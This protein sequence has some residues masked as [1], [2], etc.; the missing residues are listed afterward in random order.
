MKHPF[1]FGKDTLTV[2][3]ALALAKGSLQGI[4]ADETLLRIKKSHADVA[5][6][7]NGDRV[8]YGVNTGFGPLCTT[9]ISR[10]QTRKL[11]ENILRSHSVGVGEHVPLEVVKLMLVTKLQALSYGYSGIAPE[12]LDRILWFLDSNITPVVP[13]Q[14]SV[15]ASG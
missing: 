1:Q 5:D 8:V 15:G 3:S 12:T 2:G 10:E 9:I 7:A 13:N 14:G 6:I 4:F 11:Q